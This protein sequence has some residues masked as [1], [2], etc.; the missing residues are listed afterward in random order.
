MAK[1][2]PLYTVERL[3]AGILAVGGAYWACLLLLWLFVPPAGLVINAIYV[4]G[5]IVYAGWC[6][7]ALNRF[8]PGPRVFVWVGSI[9]VNGA[10]LLID[11]G[12][13][14][15]QATPPTALDLKG[16]WW[17]TTIVISV[18]GLLISL[19]TIRGRLRASDDEN[20]ELQAEDANAGHAP[21]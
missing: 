12:F 9:V 8:S 11:L 1:Q 13:F 15:G 14:D 5:W 10:Y 3:L 18:L 4:P 7:V 19:T 2:N 20:A 17:I 16:A 21:G 6:Y